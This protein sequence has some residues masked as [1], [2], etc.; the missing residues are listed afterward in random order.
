MC[1][2][3]CVWTGIGPSGVNHTQRDGHGPSDIPRILIHTHPSNTSSIQPTPH[4]YLHLDDYERARRRM[5]WAK[6]GLVMSLALLIC[7]VLYDLLYPTPPP[8][9]TQA[10][11]SEG[12]EE[13]GEGGGD[14]P[15]P[16]L[17]QQEPNPGVAGGNGGGSGLA[18]TA[19]EQGRRRQQHQQQLASASPLL[20]AAALMSSRERGGVVGGGG[21][22]KVAAEK[23]D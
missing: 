21:E 5:R 1:V 10:P 9:P 20:A 8:P 18:A 11:V 16:S 19:G 22:G 15:A 2:H 3:V 4:R 7:L 13:G 12:E 23:E 6:A 14:P 17:P